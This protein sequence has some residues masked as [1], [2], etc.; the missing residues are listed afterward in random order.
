MRPLCLATHHHRTRTRNRQRPDPGLLL[1]MTALDQL[2]VLLLVD[3]GEIL[4]RSALLSAVLGRPLEPGTS[5]LRFLFHD[6]MARERI[7]NW[8][9]FASASVAGLRREAG[10]HPNDEQLHDLIAELRDTPTSRAGG[11]TT[12]CGTMPRPPNASSTRPPDH[13]PSTSK[14]SPHRTSRTNT[15]SSKP[16]NPTPPPPPLGPRSPTPAPPWPTRSGPTTS[17]WAC[18]PTVSACGRPRCTSM[19]PAWPTSPTA[20]PHGFANLE[21]PD[22]FQKDTGIDESFT[23]MINLIDQGLL[24]NQS[25]HRPPRRRLPRPGH[26]ETIG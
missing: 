17:A 20:S 24:A 9:E 12:P 7:V 5:F 25:Q 21:A 10:R 19:S 18:S 23:W 15:L 2:S 13:S 8:A 14:S 11:T 4:A 3:R 6:P 16:L 1:L 22:S 26:H